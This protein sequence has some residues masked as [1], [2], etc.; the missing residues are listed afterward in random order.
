M[1][2]DQA[3]ALQ[4]LWGDSEAL[5]EWREAG[6]IAE[7]FVNEP[8]RHLQVLH[9]PSAATTAIPTTQVKGGA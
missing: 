2:W 5:Q 6:I 3:Q 7:V 1:F 8:A 9:L 4:T